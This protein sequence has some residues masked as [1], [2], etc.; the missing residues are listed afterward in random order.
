MS[1]LQLWFDTIIIQVFKLNNCSL[2]NKTYKWKQ[3]YTIVVS[4]KIKA[5]HLIV[6]QFDLLSASRKKSIISFISQNT[7]EQK[8][9]ENKKLVKIELS[10]W[11]VNLRSFYSLW[12]FFFFCSFNQLL[13]VRM[14]YLTICVRLFCI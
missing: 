8:E 10:F 7:T 1:V 11:F 2:L 12:F 9:N 3:K 5:I 14:F 4:K 13:L 6:F